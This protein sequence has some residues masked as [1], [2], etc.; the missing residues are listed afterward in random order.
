[1]EISGK[2]LLL[3]GEIVEYESEELKDAYKKALKENSKF[4]NFNPVTLKIKHDF[5]PTRI[6][7]SNKQDERKWGGM[8]S[9][10]LIIE[11]T[12]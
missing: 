7:I 12:E 5:K 11:E 9:A 4:K 8:T 1:M 3:E 10:T 6:T 2:I